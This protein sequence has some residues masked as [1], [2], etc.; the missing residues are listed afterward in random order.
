MP[1]AV[2]H[3]FACDAMLGRLARWLCAVGYEASLSAEFDD[4]ELINLS[5]TI[6]PQPA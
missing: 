6:R 4:R 2:E 3:R 5:A 1:S